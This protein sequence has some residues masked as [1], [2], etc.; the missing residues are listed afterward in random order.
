[1][2]L[3]KFN[4]GNLMNSKAIILTVGK[5]DIGCIDTCGR[6]IKETSLWFF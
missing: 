2:L 3:F 4:A 6:W 1:V 5:I